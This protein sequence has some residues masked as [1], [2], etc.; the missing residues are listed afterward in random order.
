MAVSGARICVWKWGSCV[1]MAYLLMGAASHGQCR[2][3]DFPEK[4][5]LTAAPTR[6]IESSSPD[7]VQTGVLQTE[8]GFAHSWVTQDASLNA[9]TN[10][11]KLGVWCNAELRWSMSNYPSASSGSTT[12]SGVGDTF[13]AA[14]YRVLR[15]SK[16]RP[17]TAFAY[18]VK[19]AT[20][21]AGL[22]SGMTDHAATL[23][24]GKT[25]H[26]TTG[27]FNVTYFAIGQP[28]GGFN[29]KGEWT[30]AL[31]HPLKRHFAL[32]GEAY[33]DSRLNAMNDPYGASTW[34][35]NYIHSPRLVFDVGASLA[36]TS[37][38]GA[39]GNSVFGGV[40]YALADVY[41]GWH[42]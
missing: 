38:P 35:L 12:V 6:P 29:G 42:H 39:P 36:L 40:T 16:H 32:I 13:I 5:G 1:L 14:Q 9:F 3:S 21:D 8:F 25:V 24:L 41:R 15:E 26:G 34:V 17:S 22:G 30:V 10:L 31:S 11:M 20:A 28:A 33:G 2:P 7:P 19:S 27:V 18:T 37:G 23:M 4:G